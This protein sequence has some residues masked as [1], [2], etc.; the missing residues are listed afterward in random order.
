MKRITIYLTISIF[1]LSCDPS[2]EGLESINTGN[3][4]I[5]QGLDFIPDLINCDLGDTVFFD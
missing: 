3:T 1:F 5:T 2:K 4:V